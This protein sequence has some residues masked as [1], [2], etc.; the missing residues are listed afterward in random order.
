MD[1]LLQR[2][3]DNGNSTQGL[4]FEKVNGHLHWHSHVLEDEYRKIKVMGETRIDAGLWELKIS[5]FLSTK[6][7]KAHGFKSGDYLM[8]PVAALP[9]LISTTPTRYVVDS[10]VDADNFILD[11]LSPLT[12]KHR[13][14]YNIPPF[15]NWFKHHIEITGLP[16]HKSVYIHAGNRETHTDA[17]V[18]L[19]DIM[20][21]HIIGADKMESSIAAVRRF[22]NVCYPHLLSGKRSYLEIRDEIK[23]I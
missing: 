23:L 4:W 17:C 7:Q 9:M 1:W 18:L 14:A 16:R 21:N 22:Y 12:L 8:T 15:G 2:Y 5:R 10:V 11:T 6:N 3:S 19:G 20:H 13:I